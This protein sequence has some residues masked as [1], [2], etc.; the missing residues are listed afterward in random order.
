VEYQL[1]FDPGGALPDW[2]KTLVV[3]NLAHDTLDDL[4]ERV[5]WARARGLYATRVAELARTAQHGG[6]ASAR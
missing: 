3:K 4:R 1:E 5:G 6:Y 2:L